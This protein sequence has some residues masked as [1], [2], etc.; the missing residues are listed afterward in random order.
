MGTTLT[1]R[2]HKIHRF[3]LSGLAIGSLLLIAG[4]IDMFLLEKPFYHRLESYVVLAPAVVVILRSLNPPI[5]FIRSVMLLAGGV[6][7]GAAP[8]LITSGSSDVTNQGLII[9]LAGAG[10]T[11]IGFSRYTP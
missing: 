4:L 5:G 8:L 3:T 2:H 10:V 1:K 6:M 7:I 9:L 11:G